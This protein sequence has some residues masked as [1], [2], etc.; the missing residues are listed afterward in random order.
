MM[1]KPLTALP[2]LAIPD[3]LHAWALGTPPLET[4]SRV[5]VVAYGLIR[6]MLM[7]KVTMTSLN[8]HMPNNAILAV[9]AIT[10]Q[11]CDTAYVTRIFDE[12]NMPVQELSVILFEKRYS[13]SGQKCKHNAQNAEKHRNYLEATRLLVSVDEMWKSADVAVL[14]RIDTELV[15]PVEVPALP[16]GRI[17][18]PHLLNGG[19]VNDRYLVGTVATV[20]KLVNARSKLINAECVYGE[21]TLV[22]LL[23]ELGLNVSFTRTRIIRRLENLYVPDIDRVAFLGNMPARTWMMRAN[24]LARTLVCNNDAVCLVQRVP[25]STTSHTS[26]VGLSHSPAAPTTTPANAR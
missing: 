15:S 8:R 21:E 20:K 24:S 25:P 6:S 3:W 7:L 4:A 13:I 19:L 22:R 10:C 17:L 18:V 11:S 2:R 1:V 14:W 12:L 23:Y 16:V 5:L 9:R 26:L